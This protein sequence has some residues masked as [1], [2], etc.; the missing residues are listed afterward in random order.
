MNTVLNTMKVLKK[1]NLYND[2]PPVFKI[3]YKGDILYANNSA[4]KLLHELGVSANKKIPKKFIEEHPDLFKPHVNTEVIILTKS[5]A[6]IFD[7]VS[8]DEEGYI[9]FYSNQIKH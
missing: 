8:F 3:N 4:M 1:I 7:V 9:G 5:N 2:S 6:C